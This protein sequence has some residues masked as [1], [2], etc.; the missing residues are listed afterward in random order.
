MAV[1]EFVAESGGRINQ[2]AGNGSANGE[3]WPE[4]CIFRILTETMSRQCS[5]AVAASFQLAVCS[6]G[7][8]K[9]CRHTRAR[10]VVYGRF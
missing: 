3:D 9:T 5:K 10:K 4:S 1:L 8:F 6:P 2:E 7:K